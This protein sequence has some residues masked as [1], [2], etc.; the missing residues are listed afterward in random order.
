MFGSVGL[1]RDVWGNRRRALLGSLGV[2][3]ILG[4]SD[5]LGICRVLGILGVRGISCVLARNRSRKTLA[6]LA[7]LS[8]G[9]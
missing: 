2:V 3:G 9:P 4:L 5:F 6:L 8:L 1:L 7:L